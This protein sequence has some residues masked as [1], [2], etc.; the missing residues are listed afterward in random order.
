[1]SWSQLEYEP[2]GVVVAEAQALSARHSD[3]CG[4]TGRAASRDDVWFVH[5]VGDIARL[6][7]HSALLDD[8]T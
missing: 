8:A 4:V 7:P 1:M 2:Y 5:P 6:A 3:A